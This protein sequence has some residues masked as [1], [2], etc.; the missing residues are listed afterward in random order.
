MGIQG[1]AILN[2]TGLWVPGSPRTH[3]S[4][5]CCAD[6][7][8]KPSQGSLAKPV[9]AVSHEYR[10]ALNTNSASRRARTCASLRTE[11]MSH[12]SAHR[13]LRLTNQTRK[14]ADIN[15]HDNQF[16][17]RLSN[18]D[19]RYNLHRIG[20]RQSKWENYQ[21]IAGEPGEG[22]SKTLPA[23]LAGQAADDVAAAAGA[24]EHRAT[25]EE[26]PAPLPAPRES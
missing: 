16:H 15:H 7:F 3:R 21:G 24:R 8:A 19:N 2:D 1:D 12:T 9:P 25:A 22:K 10:R 23:P 6:L 13:L 5:H 11:P 26:P 18:H 14:Q 4:R 20:Q 17:Q